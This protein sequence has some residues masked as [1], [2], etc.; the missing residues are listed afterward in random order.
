MPSEQFFTLRTS[1]I[2]MK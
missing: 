1:N 2:F